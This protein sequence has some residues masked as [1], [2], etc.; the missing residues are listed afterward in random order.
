[1]TD[2]VEAKETKVVYC[3]TK[4][5]I[6]DFYTKPLQGALFIKHRNSMLGINQDNMAKYMK[7]HTEYMASLDG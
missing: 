3:P 6:A 5:M 1:M 7:L 4:D 2:R